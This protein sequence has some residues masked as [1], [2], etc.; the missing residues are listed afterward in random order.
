LTSA[1][2]SG[3]IKLIGGMLETELEQILLQVAQLTLQFQRG[4]SCVP[5]LPSSS[6]TTIL[7]LRGFFFL[8]DLALQG[9]LVAGQTERLTGS[10]FGNAGNLEHDTAG[11]H[12]SNPVLG[13]TFTG[14]HTGIGRLLGNGL[15]RKILI[16]T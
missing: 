2:F 3:I 8:D 12:D 15:V 1:I 9:Q 7:G 4:T 5:Q 16:Q 13:G 14:T 11:L 6:F 10:L